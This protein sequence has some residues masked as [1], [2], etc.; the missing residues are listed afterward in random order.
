MIV[1]A[2]WMI[3][4]LCLVHRTQMVMESKRSERERNKKIYERQRYITCW[5]C[6]WF[7]LSRCM[8]WV[9]LCFM[10]LYHRTY[11]RFLI[12]RTCFA[13]SVFKHG[14]MYPCPSRGRTTDLT[15]S[16]LSVSI[17][18]WRFEDLI[19][20]MDRPLITLVVPMSVCDGH[21]ML[22]N[23]Q[24]LLSLKTPFW[25]SFHHLRRS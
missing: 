10:S 25:H 20:D 6:C 2:Y 9:I 5:E 23:Q 21:A 16:A 3:S 7:L 19:H 13:H 24:L 15:L 1:V 17:R 12:P 8:S 11:L 14:V 18:V 22:P 4:V